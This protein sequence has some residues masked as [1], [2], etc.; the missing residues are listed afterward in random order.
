MPNAGGFSAETSRY[1]CV[2]VQTALSTGKNM[3]VR[4]MAA[5]RLMVRRT[6]GAHGQRSCHD[7]SAQQEI[8]MNQDRFAGICKKIVG[9]LEVRWGLLTND[10]QAIAAG[11]RDQRTGK[12]LER[13]GISRE[14]AARQLDEFL[15]R[16][17]NWNLLNH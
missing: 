16:N 10:P 12:N 7:A 5:V 9:Y 1:P 2:S 11:S 6:A 3:S 15:K 14:N 4:R 13:I 17:R 8:D